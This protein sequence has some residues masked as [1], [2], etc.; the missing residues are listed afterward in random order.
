MVAISEEETEGKSEQW[1][2]GLNITTENLYSDF[3]IPFKEIMNQNYWMLN[4]KKMLQS[5]N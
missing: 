2:N 1:P 4:D 5:Q 3:G